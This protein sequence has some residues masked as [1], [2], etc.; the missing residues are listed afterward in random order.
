[1]AR[2]ETPF[3]LR[4]ARA[5]EAQGQGRLAFA[6]WQAWRYPAVI[7]VLAEQDPQLP[8]AASATFVRAKGLDILWAA[9][10]ALR[11]LPGA[12]VIAT[13]EKPLTLTAGRRLQLAAESGTTTGLLLIEDGAGSPAVET[14]WHCDP[15][16]GE[17]T[18]HRWSR[19]KNKKGPTGSWTLDWDGSSAAFDMVSAPA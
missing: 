11:R 15:L 5:H 7:W 3:S 13:P 19:I 10:E 8:L 6:L 16:A 4:P 17:S 2:D 14:R 9:E 12:L 18:L 1:M